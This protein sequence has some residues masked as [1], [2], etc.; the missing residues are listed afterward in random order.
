[1]KKW[2]RSSG[3]LIAWVT[4]AIALGGCGP[5]EYSGVL[6]D[7]GEVTLVQTQAI[8][9]GNCPQDLM[10]SYVKWMILIPLWAFSP[11]K[12]DDIAEECTFMLEE[13]SG[14]SCQYL[15]SNNVLIPLEVDKDVLPFCG[16]FL[17]EYSG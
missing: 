12:A 14:F 3:K 10:D 11:S 13:Y 16:N 17:E 9:A 1:M 4:L 8:G 7:L 6:K 2:L 15:D 5:K